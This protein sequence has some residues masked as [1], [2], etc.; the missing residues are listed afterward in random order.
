MISHISC[1]A[2]RRPICFEPANL[3]I[4][5]QKRPSTII[6]RV[7]DT[8]APPLPSHSHADIRP[9]HPSKPQ[10]TSSIDLHPAS[11]VKVR[12][13]PRRPPSTMLPPSLPLLP[14]LHMHLISTETT[15]LSYTTVLAL[16]II[17]AIIIA[18]LLLLCVIGGVRNL[19]RARDRN[20]AWNTRRVRRNA[21]GGDTGSHDQG[22]EGAQEQ[23]QGEDRAGTT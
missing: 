16:L 4:Y 22:E 17:D 18:I 6:T 12:S 19:R 1:P 21:N 20:N 3:P 14:T 13:D 5:C 2:I 15:T 7:T 11:T 8:S 10:R 9:I 23:E